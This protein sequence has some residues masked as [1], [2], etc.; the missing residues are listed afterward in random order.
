MYCKF[1]GFSEKPFNI[2]PSPRFLYLSK[3]HREA[4]AHLLFGI[5]NHS[6]FI[7]LTGEVG[8]G[9]TTV[10]RTVLSQLEEDRYRT[11]MILNPCLSAT[12]LLRNINSEF[13]IPHEN[14]EAGS[15]LD[16]LN[17]FLLEENRAGRTVVLVIDEAQ[18][19]APAVLEQIRLI[20]NLETESDKL[21]QI[22]LAGQPELR[23]LLEK[24]ELRQLAQRITVRY[25]LQ[26]LDYDDSCSYIR[27]RIQVAGGG[28]WI[29]FTSGALR[30]IFRFAKGSPRLLNI[31]C[32]RALLVAYT[33]ETQE[34]TARVVATAIDELTGRAGP[35]WN[36][37][38]AG[39]IA[40]C[41]IAGTLLFLLSGSRTGTTGA[42]SPK[43]ASTVNDKAAAK[44]AVEPPAASPTAPAAPAKTEQDTGSPW[45]SL[46]EGGSA[47][48]AAVASRWRLVPADLPLGAGNR[49]GITG[50]A[51]ESGLETI[52]LRGT[53]A[54]LVRRGVPLIVEVIPPGHRDSRYLAII[55]IGKGTVLIEP[56][57][58]G[59]KRIALREL[60]KVYSGRGYLLWKN[61]QNI[62]AN[63]STDA[64]GIDVI[65]LQTLLLGTGSLE[66]EPTGTFDQATRDSIARFRRVQQLPG[67]DP[68]DAQLLFQLYRRNHSFFTP[69]LAG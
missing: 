13:G 6:G 57:V 34:V 50:L 12:E 15:L 14:L 8:T 20:S 55:G 40:A 46:P 4:L 7:E 3:I 5:N 16:N 24:P 23:Q 58:K 48:V 63:L 22:I 54:S 65:R 69:G 64:V 49:A 35:R 61:Y 30:K 56:A 27:H 21:I 47:A 51:R 18:N 60:E 11:A 53:L 38:L 41:L 68:V 59:N 52:P 25:S 31:A 9:K 66:G 62:P 43:G 37:P 39:A 33:L 29:R 19:L 1:Y 10:L 26:A 42:P 17:L 45:L 28:A 67:R 32:D 36:R 44:V 2:T